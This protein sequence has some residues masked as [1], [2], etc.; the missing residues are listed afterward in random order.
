MSFRAIFVLV[1]VTFS[2]S[3]AAQ[4]AEIAILPPELPWSGKSLELALSADHEWATLFEQSGLERTP[5]YDETV[6]WLQRLVDEAPELSMVSLGRSAEGREIWMVVASREGAA[7]AAA[8]RKNGRPILLAHA[9]IHS[10]EIDGKDAGMMLLRDMTVRKT[11]RDLLEKTNLL[12][13]PILS[14]DA[15]ERFSRFG[16]VNQRGPVESGWR[17]NRRNLNLNRDYSKLETEERRSA[18]PPG[19]RRA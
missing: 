3:A 16:R 2:A 8:L 7:D 17:T 12:F 14:V 11:R 4:P 1:A 18:T 10:G 5:R 19:S 6:S 13:I 15:H 9:G